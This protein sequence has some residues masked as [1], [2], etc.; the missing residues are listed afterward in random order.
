MAGCDWLIRCMIRHEGPAHLPIDLRA[1]CLIKWRQ[2]GNV[3][4][5][6]RLLLELLSLLL[7][8]SGQLAGLPR[9]LWSAWSSEGLAWQETAAMGV[10][11]ASSRCFVL[12][13]GPGAGRLCC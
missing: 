4:A 5:A 12:Q 9:Q 7:R 3:R 13:H 8:H 2:P 1:P 10:L 11:E 6:Q